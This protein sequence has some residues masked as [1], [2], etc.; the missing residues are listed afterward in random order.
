[1]RVFEQLFQARLIDGGLSLVD[2]LYCCLV[3]IDADDF[4]APMR[5]VCSQGQSQFTYS[6]NSKRFSAHVTHY[7]LISSFILPLA[8]SYVLLMPSSRL[9]FGSQPTSL[10]TSVI[11]AFLPLTPCGFARSCFTVMFF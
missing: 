11:S 4:V 1:M 8:H 6:D 2:S 9:I 10:L 3:Y 5:I 7:M